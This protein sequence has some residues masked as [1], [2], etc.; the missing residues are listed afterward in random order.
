MLR[1]SR[2]L[3]YASN[4]GGIASGINAIAVPLATSD[5]EPVASLTLALAG[6]PLAQPQADVLA[7][8]L[9]TEAEAIAPLLA[10][11]RLGPT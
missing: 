1:R 9:Q 3:G 7:E 4:L 10:Q 5:G 6:A 8:R 2:P 11:L